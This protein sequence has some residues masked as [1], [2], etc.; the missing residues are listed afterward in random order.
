M[1]LRW[2]FEYRYQFPDARVW[3]RGKRTLAWRGF[4]R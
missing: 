3:M 1:R 4:L 2:P